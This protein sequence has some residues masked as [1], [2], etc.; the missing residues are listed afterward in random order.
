LISEKFSIIRESVISKGEIGERIVATAGEITATIL[1]EQQ[2][3]PL[4]RAEDPAMI[5]D[6]EV[7]AVV[8]S[9]FVSSS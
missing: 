4:A 9:V 5:E 7:V 6:T 3:T 1:V 2:I 8:F